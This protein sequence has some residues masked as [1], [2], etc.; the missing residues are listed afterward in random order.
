MT[1]LKYMQ[2]LVS[3]LNSFTRKS[4]NLNH[5]S[6]ATFLYNNYKQALGILHDGQQSLPKLMHE[7][8]V[9]DESVFDVWL[10][11]EHNYLLLLSHEP[12]HET[13]QMEYWQKLVNL[14]ASKYVNI[15]YYLVY[16]NG[17]QLGW[18]SMLQVR[19]GLFQCQVPCD[20]ELVMLGPLLGSRLHDNTQLKT[21]RRT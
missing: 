3:N 17:I 9:T 10:D 7:L 20:L 18:R 19:H 14:S 21:T 13:L 12:K 5:E 16:T 2:T 1:N 8:G 4:A 15:F 11:K 6:L